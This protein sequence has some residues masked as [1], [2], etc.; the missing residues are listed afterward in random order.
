MTQTRL[1]AMSGNIIKTRKQIMEELGM[2][3]RTV[4]ERLK[5]IE[6]ECRPG[7]RYENCQYC[8]QRSGGFVRVNW[9]IWNDY[10][11]YRTR[12]KE[13]NLRKSVPPYNP[14]RVA[15]EFGMYQ[16]KEMVL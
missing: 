7:G 6:A 2:S 13:K 10:E 9:L 12:L 16:D 5:E 14:Y 3:K 8:V 11:T 4:E 15:Y 1:F